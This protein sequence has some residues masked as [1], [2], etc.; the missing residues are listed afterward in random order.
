MLIDALGAWSLELGTW[1]LDF[2]EAFQ[3]MECVPLIGGET[4]TRQRRVAKC[5]FYELRTGILRHGFEMEF[6]Q[7]LLFA[8]GTAG[9]VARGPISRFFAS[10]YYRCLTP[11]LRHFDVLVML[12]GG[13]AYKP[14][15]T[16]SRRISVLR[17]CGLPFLSGFCPC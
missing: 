9:K 1:N 2:G 15:V 12:S 10:A 4:K 3:L 7:A 16:R 6:Q 14:G 13:S 8:D 11:A 5:E 17:G